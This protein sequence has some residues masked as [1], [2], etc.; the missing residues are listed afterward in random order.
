[1]LARTLVLAAALCAGSAAVAQTKTV[2]DSDGQ[3]ST[4][5]AD[6]PINA[7]CPIGKEPIVASAGT[8][9]YGGHTLGFCCPGCAGEF[10]A[11]DAAKK[12][13]FVRIALAGD[14][15]PQPAD[16][17]P[18]EPATEPAAAAQLRPYTLDTCAVSGEKLGSMGD[19]VVNQYDGREIRFC[20]E[21][22]VDE[23]EAD[24]PASLAKVD[25]AMVKQQLAHYPLD[26]CAVRG[27]K[28]GSM[29]EPV[30]MIHDNRLARFCCAG[31]ISAFNADPEKY[32]A[33]MDEK[34]I[35]AQAPGYP[36][37]ECPVGGH[38][39]EEE[40][41]WY[42]VVY[43]NRL[44]RLCCEG[45]EWKLHANPAGYLAKLDR[46]YADAQRDSYPLSTC[47][48]GGEKLDDGAAEIVAG[49]QLV[50]LCC[51]GCIEDFEASPEKYLTKIEE[52]KAANG[53]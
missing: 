49:T 12:D 45:C 9:T 8:T 20:C 2:V 53:G 42:D 36:M 24:V 4:A 34:I 50:R 18:A 13:E 39:P 22:C 15:A 43:M 48:V 11:W 30:N 32:F 23:F 37:T 40:G 6:P 3:P 21:G 28:L 51:E 29:G 5:T 25:E 46:A 47:P 26:T 1:M 44:V 38:G 52:A 41:G 33:Q 31:C 35:A 19:P 16:G 17:E 7:M 14:A 27:G 10:H